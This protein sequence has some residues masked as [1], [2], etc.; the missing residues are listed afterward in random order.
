MARELWLGPILNDNRERLIARCA[1][2][3]ASGRGGEFVYLAATKPLMDRVVEGLASRAPRTARTRRPNVFLLSGFSREILRSARFEATGAPLPYYASIESAARPAQMPLFGRIVAQLAAAD[4][5]PSFGRLAQ[6][7]GLV[8]SLAGLVTEIQRAGKTAVEYHEIV[9]RRAALQR[10]SKP[11]DADLAAAGAGGA[12]LSL[13]F[14]RDTARVFDAYERA[15]EEHHLTDSSRDYLRA[16]AVL[17]GTLDGRAVVVPMLD[18]VR[19]LI[20]DGLYDILPVHTA[21]LRLLQERLPETIANLNFDESNPA[22]FAAFDEVRLHYADHDFEI[23]TSHEAKPVADGLSRLRANLFN[24]NADD[25][26]ISMSDDSRAAIRLITGSDRWREL[27]A[28]AKEIKRLVID[29]SAPD[30][31]AV[32]FRSRDPYEAIVRE[33]FA[34]EHIAVTIG[35]R[36]ALRDLPSVRA[37]V[38]VLDAAAGGRLKVAKLVALLKSDYFALAPVTT[39]A[40]EPQAALPFEAPPV[41][42]AAMELRSDEVENAV[43]YVGA[44]LALDEWLSR[45]ERLIADIDRTTGTSRHLF[46]LEQSPEQE[47]DDAESDDSEASS[48]SSTHSRRDMPADSLRRASGILDAVGEIVAGIPAA[49]SPADMAAAFRSALDRLCFRQRMI[50]SARASASDELALERAA[51]DLRGLEGLDAAIAAVV[52]ASEI[53]TLGEE[54][55]TSTMS[56]AEFE[57]DLDRA[58]E[59]NELTV[60]AGDPGGVRALTV[61]DM[62]GLSFPTVFVVGLVEGE[63][64][65]RARTDWIYPQTERANFREAGLPLEDISPEESLRREEHDFYQAVCRATERLYVT[66]PITGDDD[67]DTIPSY[68]LAEVERATGVALRADVFVPGFNAEHL[69]DASTSVELARSVV[70]AREI[71]PDVAARLGVT[72]D[73]V[74]A[75]DAFARA[76]DGSSRSVVDASTLR[77]IDVEKRRE[78]GPFDEFDGRI[79][80]PALRARIDEAF[81]LHTYSATELSEFGNCGFR[82]FS[83]RVLKLEPR[84]EAALDLQGLD[85]GVLLHAILQRFFEQHRGASLSDMPRD[86]LHAELRA[87]ANTELDEFERGLPPLSPKLWKIE[88]EV[89]LILLERFLDDELNLQEKIAPTGMAPTQFELGFGVQY[90]GGDPDSSS[91]TLAIA[92]PDG[93]TIRIRGKIDRVDRAADGTV[94]AYDYKT[95]KGLGVKDMREGRDVQ[96]GIYLDALEGVFGIPRDSIAGGGYYALSAPGPRRNNG[97]YRRDKSEYTGMNPRGTAHA[98]LA[99]AEFD[100]LRSAIDANIVESTKRIRAADFRLVPSLNEKT[101]TYCDYAHVCRFNRHRVLVKKKRTTD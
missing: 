2:L 81:R 60:R 24:P 52:E 26:P 1:E 47:V 68:F 39:A 70:R 85:R 79:A 63:F 66:R 41:E 22:A 31:I 9:E 62:R 96:L 6:T 35:E 50:D 17:R 25:A 75:L 45:A 64:P 100:Q 83:K 48:S 20:I 21:M 5:L 95:G 3:I 40:S 13:E 4:Q 87:V 10:E 23:R 43:A 37:A 98:I 11:S 19:L 74:A 53:A 82:F 77:R 86:T 92:G 14:D 93:E 69:L 72:A 89:L 38:K 33:V 18:D 54:R 32:V 16:L 58:L 15:V 88:R 99:P 101:C 91:D 94:V 73:V 44:D 71:V 56:R 27:R 30:E 90:L 78:D 34:D 49:A 97:L 59:A 36:R 57:A 76:A 12:T 80:D 28:V 84:V 42:S 67:G 55:Q 51:L 65:Q 8:V 7:D 29:G 61:T 46:D